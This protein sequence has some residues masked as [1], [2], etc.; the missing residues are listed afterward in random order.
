MEANVTQLQA[1]NQEQWTAL[2]AL[3]N[4]NILQQN[5]ID[6]MG[7]LLQSLLPGGNN[8]YTL[9]Y[10]QTECLARGAFSTAFASY[11]W[12][13]TDKDPWFDTTL[14]SACAGVLSTP[15]C[16]VVCAVQGRKCDPCAMMQV[17][18]CSFD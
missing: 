18:G 8:S 9:P 7:L 3:F 14:A 13:T 10:N 6:A 5:Q 1:E 11:T 16:E 15:T 4:Q 17:G 12:V 2:V